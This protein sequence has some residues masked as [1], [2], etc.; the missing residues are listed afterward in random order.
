MGTIS[1]RVSEEESELIR[2][3]TSANGLNMSTFIRESVLDVIEESL[4]M[5]E[6]RIL[7][8]LERSRGEKTYSHEEAWKKVSE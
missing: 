2:E 4:Q 1:F 3:Y 5:D 6:K 7:D 8:A